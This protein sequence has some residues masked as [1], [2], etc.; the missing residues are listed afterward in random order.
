MAEVCNAARRCVRLGRISRDQA[1]E[2]ADALPNF[3]DTL[4]SGA[5]LAPR[6]AA[7]AVSLGHPVYDC[8]YVAL[9]EMQQA[10]LVTAD[11]RLLDRLRGTSWERQAV[12]LASYAE[13]S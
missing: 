2:V 3:F 13:L 1:I 6:A 5:Q 9:A 11:I 7:I 8:F 10:R 4:A 12:H